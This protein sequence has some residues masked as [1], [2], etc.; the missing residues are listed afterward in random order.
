MCFIQSIQ[1]YFLFRFFDL[2]WMND[3]LLTVSPVFFIEP[4]CNPVSS[5][6]INTETGIK[7]V[8]NNKC[9]CY[10]KPPVM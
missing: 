3:S 4:Y 1:I 8:F 5:R 6:L 2:S 7:P 10:V 9:V